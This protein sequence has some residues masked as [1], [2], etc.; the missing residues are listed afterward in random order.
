MATNKKN[1]LPDLT[2]TIIN[3]NISFYESSNELLNIFKNVSLDLVN[4]FIQI[5]EAQSSD[6]VIKNLTQ[7]YIEL[8]NKK[9]KINNVELPN[10]Y[11]LYLNEKFQNLLS[12]FKTVIRKN[13]DDINVSVFS[14]YSDD[15]GMTLE[16][17]HNLGLTNTPI[18]DSFYN[19]QKTGAPI[20]IPSVM[21]NKVNRSTLKNF[22]KMSLKNDALMKRN[23]RNIAGYG[24]EN[25]SKTS[26]GANLVYDNFQSEVMGQLVNEKT[27]SIYKYFGENLGDLITFYKNLNIREQPENKS[28]LV[29]YKNNIEGVENV[30]DM[31]NNNVYST[32]KSDKTFSTDDILVTQ[33]STQTIQNVPSTTTQTTAT[34]SQ[35][36]SQPVDNTGT[37]SY[38]GGST[39]ESIGTG[40]GGSGGGYSGY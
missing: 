4:Y 3:G 30:L 22:K 7:K 27:S 34:I 15:I 28:Y 14:N 35:T 18:F 19:L 20:T 6:N 11:K 24:L 25:M 26:H 8:N 5:N 13:V 10:N 17:N 29:T 1:I 33:E 2:D 36:D 31:F 9:L 16:I 12:I 23:L 37:G 21:I 32:T 38:G 39:G 40:S